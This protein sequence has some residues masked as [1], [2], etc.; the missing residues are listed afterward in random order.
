[1]TL[2]QR[3]R[4]AGMGLGLAL[5][6]AA[7]STSVIGDATLVEDSSDH[8]V[9]RFHRSDS[10]I[11]GRYIVVLQQDQVQRGISAP[12][13]ERAASLADGYRADVAM[14]LEG[15]VNG[16]VAEMSEED[17]IALSEDPGVA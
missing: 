7:C 6:A 10:P 17:A 15:V 1:M 5:T 9:E 13:G 12:V 3:A 8:L 16:F 2:I 14:K 11:P 4:R